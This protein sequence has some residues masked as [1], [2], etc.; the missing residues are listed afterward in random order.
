MVLIYRPCFLWAVGREQWGPS[1][2][3]MHFFAIKTWLDEQRWDI[4]SAWLR[5]NVDFESHIYIYVYI[6]FVYCVQWF[7]FLR[8]S[9]TKH[10]FP[11]VYFTSHDEL[12]D[13]FS[14]RYVTWNPR[15]TPNRGTWCLVF[16]QG[17]PRR[18]IQF[19]GACLNPVGKKSFHILWWE[20]CEPP[21]SIHWFSGVLSGKVGSQSLIVQ[22]IG[23]KLF[24]F[25]TNKSLEIRGDQELLY[26]HSSWNVHFS[27]KCILVLL[28][29]VQTSGYT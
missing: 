7:L 5:E 29:L 8:D 18:K 23:G 17:L 22:V 4:P 14:H 27:C 12:E 25:D 15:G 28:L 20:L 21:F 10:C 1:F 16:G 13:F 3:Y 26:L 2:T 11:S 19:L 9:F 6:M 24:G